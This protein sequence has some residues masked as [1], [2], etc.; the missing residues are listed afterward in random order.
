MDI[1]NFC[2][3]AH[4]DHGKS[5][6]A[7]RFLEVTATVEKR[8]MKNQYLD[9]MDLERERGITIK[10]APVTMTYKLSAKGGP[11]S[12][13]QL[14][15]YT[16]NLIDT[17][18]H[19]DFSY[20]VS[21]SL[22]AVEGAI[23]LVDATQGI[24]AQTLAN[25]ELARNLG[26][27]IIP[28]VNK[29]DL[30]Q[31]P[32]SEAAAEL[33]SLVG[34]EPE[35]VIRVSGKT[36]QGVGELLEA[37]IQGVPAPTGSADAPLRA[38][39]FDS[40]FDS[41]RGVVV[42]VRIVDGTVAAGDRLSFLG[43]KTQSDCLEVGT[44]TPKLKAAAKLSA[45]EI[46]YIVTGL[47]TIA[48]ARVGDTITTYNLSAKGGPASGGQL[49]TEDVKPL[50]GYREVAPMVFA[51]LYP[52]ANEHVEKLRDALGKLKL[53]DAALTLEPERSAV[54]GFG[55]RAGFLGLL[56]LDIV[57]ERIRRE[58]GIEMIVAL[59]SV[60][61]EVRMRDETVQIIKSAQEMPAPTRRTEVREPIMA[62]SVVCP[63]AYVGNVMQCASSHRGE[64][65]TTEHPSPDRAIIRYEMPLAA[66]LLDFYDELK[67]STA[68]YASYSY[69]LL[70]Y[71]SCDV[72]RLDVH[73]A[74]QEM[75]EL[76][77][78]VYTDEAPGRARALV[79]KLREVLPR[80]MF[81]I[82]IQAAIGGHIIAS[83]RLSAM[84]KDVR[85]GMSG[86]DYTRKRKLLEQQKK[87]KKKMK[88]FG[89]VSIPPE[90]YMALLKK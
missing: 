11:A 82:K 30:P 20:E 80:Q 42:Y 55:F 18:G 71:H 62:V 89:R 70:S 74:E 14:T 31:A 6:L 79:E 32:P 33:A 45:G 65:Q 81:E 69:E 87:G 26:L 9:Q 34:C 37:V 84:G 39:I 35:M 19:V 38:L 54:F 75:E 16:L 49:T 8:V 2:I 86:G 77:S 78:I 51:G 29:V 44:F 90:A 63:L 46:G 68:G 47:K 67:S 12:G 56:H 24:Q 48:G 41:Y 21:R 17:P 25:F 23:L 7:D 57:R 4:I 13:G 83:E 27:A 50:P 52:A 10:L 66:M 88:E 59:P 53:N 43:T 1:R 40:V 22:A 60:A 64:Y 85:Q 5:T 15:S 61:Y 72:A 58:Y 76:A 28:A 3:V 73:I 36:G